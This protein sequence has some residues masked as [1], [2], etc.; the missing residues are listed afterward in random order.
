LN[1]ECKRKFDNRRYTVCANTRR[2]YPSHRFS[3]EEKR[4]EYQERLR[5]IEA[6]REEQM[7]REKEEEW[8][9]LEIKQKLMEEEGE[10]VRILYQSYYVARCSF[11]I[12]CFW[13]RV[14]ACSFEQ[15]KEQLR[16]NEVRFDTPEDKIEASMAK[17]EVQIY[18]H[19]Y[20]PLLYCSIRVKNIVP[21]ISSNAATLL[22][23]FCRKLGRKYRKRSKR[24]RRTLPCRRASSSGGRRK[25]RHRRRLY[26][27]VTVMVPQSTILSPYDTST[28]TL[29][30]EKGAEGG[31]GEGARGGAQA[32]EGAEGEGAEG[33]AGETREGRTGK[34]CC[35]GTRALAVINVHDSCTDRGT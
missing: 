3:Q 19:N 18:D 11:V 21:V 17:T 20:L 29:A 33:R 8:K 27:S 28:Y 32:G 26:V 1:K 5:Q 35:N 4:R 25:K 30:V 10:K 16:K 2:I 13:N 22:T 12:S 23:L 31:G 9:R 7:K 24:K 14:F 15:L 6:E 34:V